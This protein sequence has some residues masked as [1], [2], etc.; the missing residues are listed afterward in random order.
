VKGGMATELFNI[1][2]GDTEGSRRRM[3]VGAQPLLRGEV[4][5]ASTE[6]CSSRFSGGAVQ[7]CTYGERYLGHILLLVLAQNRY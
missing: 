4:T 5:V 1:D 3:D 2:W 7:I 6:R